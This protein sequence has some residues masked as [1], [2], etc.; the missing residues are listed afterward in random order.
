MGNGQLYLVAT[1]IGNLLDI[2]YRAIET[3]QA[4]DYILAE[5]TRHSMKL[6]NHYQ[7]HKRLESYH[8]HNQYTKG[9]NVI[10]QLQAGAKIALVTDAGTPGISDPGSHLV[11]L[12]IEHQVEYTIIPG[13][14][15]FV[16]GLI[17]SGF[18]SSRL[19]FDGFLPK[20][21]KH[22]VEILE[23]YQ[24]ESRT[25]I[26]YEAPHRI[27][28]TLRE[29]EHYLGGNR[30]IS[31]VREITKQYE[32]RL[33]GTAAELIQYLEHNQARGEYVLVIEGVS[34]QERKRELVE[35]QKTIPL[36]QHLAQ[37]VEQG[38]SKK[39]AIKQVAKERDIDKRALYKYLAND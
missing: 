10:A 14:V 22:R 28:Q 21:K 3:L 17:L 6:L 19:I 1:P 18:D 26:L 9:E 29:L 34:E 12:C 23:S 27:R 30:R 33:E 24:L 11:R 20:K 16:N 4:V 36:E 31:L 25:V 38:Y 15:A 5:D 8:Q 39:E 2:S 37:Y 13:P 32:Q 35:Q 7:I